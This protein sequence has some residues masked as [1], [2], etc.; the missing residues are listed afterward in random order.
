MAGQ[1]QPEFIKV[2]MSG[3]AMLVANTIMA[4]L[5][6]VKILM[7]VQGE[8]VKSSYLDQR[9]SGALDCIV[10]TYRTKGSYPCH[11]PFDL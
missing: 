6:R 9:Y 11:W 1:D 3:S 8:L 7:Q 2:V 4:P 5:H 10:R